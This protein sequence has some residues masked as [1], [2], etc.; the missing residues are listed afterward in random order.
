MRSPKLS[1][2]KAARHLL[3]LVRE[4]EISREFEIQSGSPAEFAGLRPIE[5]LPTQKMALK[6]LTKEL[7]NLE[8]ELPEGCTAGPTGDDMMKW[9]GGW[10][11]CQA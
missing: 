1:L 5:F 6:K 11:Y 4:S 2:L 7:K 8:G 3:R 9:Q 10:S